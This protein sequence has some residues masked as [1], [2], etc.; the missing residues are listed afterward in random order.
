MSV[1]VPQEEQQL[2]E[3]LVAGFEVGT[4]KTVVKYS[5]GQ[6]LSVILDV[7]KGFGEVVFEF[8]GWLDQR[9]PGAFEAFLRGAV[10]A[11]PANIPLQTF[12]R[13]HFPEA[14]RPLV[15]GDLVTKVN[16]GLTLL[17]DMIDL[18]EVRETV[19]YFRADFSA[20]RSQ[21]I[22]LR[23]YKAL[24]DS[25]HELQLEFFTIAMSLNQPQ[26][27]ANLRAIVRHYADLR[28]WAKKARDQLPGLPGAEVEE[29]WLDEFDACINVIQAA[30]SPNATSTDWTD[31]SKVSHRLK[32]ILPNA[33]RINYALANAASALRLESISQT[34]GL[35]SERLRQQAGDNNLALQQL[36]IQF[37]SRNFPA[38]AY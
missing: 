17:I 37:K 1:L 3:I 15:A 23:K 7:N 16:Q 35:I 14:L 8:L 24:H 28:R 38:F 22:N 27:S 29:L 31:L 12:C 11:Q 6:K 19:G 2:H 13:A 34:M 25:L 36:E 30:T 21:I 26:A 9:G 10:A 32:D 20:T 33:P 18:P 4:L 5:L